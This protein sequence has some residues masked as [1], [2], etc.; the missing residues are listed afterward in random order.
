VL[1]QCNIISRAVVASQSQQP[2]YRGQIAFSQLG[3]K[4]SD[5]PGTNMTGKHGEWILV[6][7]DEVLS[8]QHMHRNKLSLVV[9][10]YAGIFRLELFLPETGKS[11]VEYWMR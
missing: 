5:I 11:C 3:D 8:D 1:G 4:L 9:Y 6:Y 10:T 2:N 7:S